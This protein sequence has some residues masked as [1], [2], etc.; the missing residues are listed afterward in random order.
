MQAKEE[1]LIEQLNQ[2][3]VMTMHINMIYNMQFMQEYDLSFSHLSS[4]FFIH[5]AGCIN[6]HCLANHLGVTKAAVSQMVD[7][8]VELDLISR[9]EDPIDR[10]SKLI[11]LSKNGES[12]VQ[13]AFLT[14]RKWVP[15][16]AAS[17]TEVQEKQACQIFELMNEKLKE[18]HEGLNPEL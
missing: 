5:R 15:D 8:L 18:I 4:L 16:L 9:E 2:F 11:C 3:A 1:K 6:I 13:K 14:R 10:R 7:R 17:L 12:L